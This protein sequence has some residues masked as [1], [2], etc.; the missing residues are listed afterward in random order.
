MSAVLTPSPQA[1]PREVAI[2]ENFDAFEQLLPSILIAHS[3]KVALLRDRKVCDY[4]DTPSEAIRNGHKQFPDRM[5]SV[6]RVERNTV[7]LG[8]YSHD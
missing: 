2:K 7:D 8:W 1:S 5:F 4:F 6:Q 3:G